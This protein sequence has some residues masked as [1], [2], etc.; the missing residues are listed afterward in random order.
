MRRPPDPI[1]RA[2]LI[3]LLCGLASALAAQPIDI[4]ADR[5]EF[6][7]LKG[8]TIFVGSVVLRRGTL[9]ISADR[10]TLYRKD[11]SVT[12]TIAEGTPARYTQTLPDGREVSAE[13]R[14]IEYL[15]DSERLRLSGTA[16]LQQER[17][18]FSG[19]RIIYDIRSAKVQAEGGGNGKQ[20]VRAVI[21]PDQPAAQ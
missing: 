17:N 16:R 13:A 5:A 1:I 7:S 18:R 3:L 19:E 11:G 9:T 2:A 20:R 4:E 15:A 21:Y 10:I 14:Q 8:T 6:D 12:R